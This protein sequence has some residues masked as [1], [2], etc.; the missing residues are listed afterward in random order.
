MECSRSEV[1]VG[2]GGGRII[3][4][5]TYKFNNNNLICFFEAATVLKLFEIRINVAPVYTYKETILK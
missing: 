2:G 4:H 3:V 5:Y 1:T